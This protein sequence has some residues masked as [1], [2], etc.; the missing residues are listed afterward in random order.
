MG[1]I[2]E[3]GRERG[4]GEDGGLWTANRERE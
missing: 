3:W 2:P 4:R 1:G